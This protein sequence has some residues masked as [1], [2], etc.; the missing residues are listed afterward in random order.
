MTIEPGKHYSQ[1]VDQSFHV[2]MA[3]LDTREKSGMT[4]LLVRHEKAE[5]LLCTLQYGDDHPLPI[6]QQQL[7]LNLAEGSEISFYSEGKGSIHLTGYLVMDEPLSADPELLA[8]ARGLLVGS[9]E[10]EDEDYD[11]DEV[12]E[13]E[14]YYTDSDMDSASSQD[15][16]WQQ[17]IQDVDEEEDDDS[18]E[19]EWTP[20]AANVPKKEKKRKS[21]DDQVN[22]SALKKK[23][24]AAVEAESLSKIEMAADEAANDDIDDDE[25]EEDD[26]DFN[27]VDA[28][29]DED[30]DDDDDD[31]DYDE[32]DEEEEEEEEDDEEV[33]LETSPKK[34]LKSPT[35]KE[36]K[37][38]SGSPQKAV[39]GETESETSNSESPLKKKKK[40]KQQK[41]AQDNSSEGELPLKN[42]KAINKE[43]IDAQRKEKPGKKER[44]KTPATPVPKKIKLPS[45][46]TI[47]D[48]KLG[49]GKL[50][51]PGKKVFM[52]YRGV[53]ANNQ[54][55]FDSRLS[56]KPFMFSL[57]RGEVIQAWDDGV[58]GM[59]VGG[60]RRLIVPPS[61]GYGSQRVGPIP[62]NSTLIFDVELRQVR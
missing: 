22:L 49:E 44:A 61:Q 26:G 45:G 28:I 11:S 32:D 58:K 7:N 38:L 23:R 43:N 54:K 27:P 6:V 35:K 41:E 31:E 51:K 36:K 52:Y 25:D 18:E 50:A 2:S 48:L 57:G 4:Q 60:K 21:L 56:G 46:T 8:E 47:E 3:A 1:T 29:D 40:K 24:K 39:K 59:K 34:N 33:E 37:S 16:S 55:E 13:D 42:L 14:E 53:L 17:M 30:D 19:G 62:S 15:I 10:E 20:G 5:F 12:E 9:E